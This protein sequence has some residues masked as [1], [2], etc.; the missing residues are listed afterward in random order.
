MKSIQIG[1][2]LRRLR[3]ERHLTQ[4]QMAAEL[5][6]SPSSLNLIE[7]NRR[8]VTARVLLQ[9]AD[10]L[11]IEI[12]SLGGAGDD[13]RLTS[14]L[15]EALSDPVFEEHDVKVSDVRELVATL[16]SVGHALL[17]LY[18]SHLLQDG[19]GA[20]ELSGAGDAK[21]ENSLAVLPSEEVSELIQ[22]RLNHFPDLERA[23]EKLWQDNDIALHNLQPDLIRVL[24]QRF[25]VQVEI[26]PAERMPNLL[27]SYNPLTR[28]LALS[29]MLAPPA[30]TFQLAHQI[31]FLA[32][33]P[34][35]EHLA[36]GKLTSPASEALARSALANYF[37]GAVMMPYGRFIEAARA[38]RYDLDVLQARFGVSFEQA[39]HRLTTLRR[40]GEEGIPFHL[41]RV[42]IAGNISKRFS[43]SGIHMARFG[44]AC[45]RWN[46]YDAF[47][48]PGMLRV[49]V[50]QMPEGQTYFCV[51]RTISSGR[52]GA[53]RGGL[54]Q[55]VEK[56]AIGLGCA[57]HHARNIVY[58]DGLHLDD[59]Q[60]VTPI[61][62]SCRTCPRTNC[63]DRA[64]PA[65]AQKLEI[66]DNS[67][68]LS[69]Y[70]TAGT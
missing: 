31:A 55:R 36:G 41:I 34:Q 22:Q 19:S 50:S 11:K 14:D 1:G 27:R 52:Q 29:E 25:A 46:V 67:R 54:P 48:T 51:A 61:G 43:A 47:A 13:E 64:S 12:G 35:L 28:R 59:P 16:P 68:G 26:V 3:Q 57:V 38:S 65:L 20:G 63:P 69:P 9:I 2:K 5:G 62:V 8:P 45:P 33:R 24:S 66:D 7:S 70:M 56:L 49:A 53:H 15:M 17:A 58:A 10:K 18:R 42:D 21:S 44:A 60:I 30:R 32:H 37:A 6:I 39:C 23:A 4:A 40:A